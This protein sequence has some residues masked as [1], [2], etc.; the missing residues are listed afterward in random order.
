MPRDVRNCP[1]VFG[2]R[3]WRVLHGIHLCLGTVVRVCRALFCFQSTSWLAIKLQTW[4]GE[5][6]LYFNQEIV[7]RKERFF[8]SI[9]LKALIRTDILIQIHFYSIS[10]LQNMTTK[11]KMV[12]ISL[13]FHAS[14]D[15]TPGDADVENQPKV[16]GVQTQSSKHSTNA[17]IGLA[18]A[19]STS[20]WG[21]YL[22]D[23]FISMKTSLRIFFWCQ[24]GV[25]NLPC[26]PA[27]RCSTAMW[28]APAQ[29][30]EHQVQG[31]I[32]CKMD[33]LLCWVTAWSVVIRAHNWEGESICRIF[34]AWLEEIGSLVAIFSLHQTLNVPSRFIP[35]SGP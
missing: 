13:P 14:P 2:C 30:E 6:W 29:M 16:R 17:V 24:G 5:V 12:A 35:R 4:P 31:A 26:P 7:A 10:S 27:L 11:G 8:R 32:R 23:I 34:G 1:S 19:R 28:S 15:P 18:L 21:R 25:W 9:Q 33:A 20:P 22:W 3:G